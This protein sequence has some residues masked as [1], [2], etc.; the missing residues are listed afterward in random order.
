[1][2]Q[3]IICYHG[4]RYLI[5]QTSPFFIMLVSH[6]WMRVWI[7]AWVSWRTIVWSTSIIISLLLIVVGLL[8]VLLLVV[9]LL[10]VLHPLIVQSWLVNGWR[11]TPVHMIA[12][13]SF[14]T[15]S[16][17]LFRHSVLFS[18]IFIIISNH[19]HIP[20]HVILLHPWAWP[21]CILFIMNICTVISLNTSLNTEL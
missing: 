1:M 3:K 8:V 7:C 17:S 21:T 14:C 2:L 20:S 9:W 5:F 4:F 16:V 10:M 12:L 18:R 6:I 13:V 19:S 15:C 11:T